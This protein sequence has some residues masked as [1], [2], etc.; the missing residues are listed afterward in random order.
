MTA[1]FGMPGHLELLIIGLMCLLFLVAPVAIIAI[2]L[3][4]TKSQQKRPP[5]ISPNDERPAS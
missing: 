2:V 5:D 3:L 1:M 4:V